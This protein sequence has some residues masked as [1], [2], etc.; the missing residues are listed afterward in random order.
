MGILQ[1][2]T[3]RFWIPLLASVGLGLLLLLV[4]WRQYRTARLAERAKE[5][6]QLQ[7]RIFD[8]EKRRCP[9]DDPLLR[10]LDALCGRAELDAKGRQVVREYIRLWLDNTPG[11]SMEEF[12]GDLPK[13]EDRRDELRDQLARV[14]T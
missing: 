1:N 13:F 10:A 6:I 5:R 2:E 11:V 9:A 12:G 14:L 8:W 3:L 4:R 7:E